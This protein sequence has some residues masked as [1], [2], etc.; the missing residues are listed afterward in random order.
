[1]NRDEF[2]KCMRKRDKWYQ[3]KISNKINQKWLSNGERAASQRIQMG[4]RK[5]LNDGKLE[6]LHYHSFRSSYVGI[7]LE[8]CR[9]INSF[10][11]AVFLP[12]DDVLS[13]EEKCQEH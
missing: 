8:I 6:I 4:K 13:H 5:V 7:G 10:H 3:G 11:S 9:L 12:Q 1:M 2:V